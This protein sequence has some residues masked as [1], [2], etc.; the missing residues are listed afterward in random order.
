MSDT[1]LILSP[2]TSGW[3]EWLLVLLIM[4]SMVIYSHDRQD[5]FRLILLTLHRWISLSLT[6]FLFLRPNECSWTTWLRILAITVTA[7]V[8]QLISMGVVLDT[9]EIKIRD[10]DPYSLY[11]QIW[12][13]L[14]SLFIP[15]CILCLHFP[16]SP[17]ISTPCVALSAGVLLVFFITNMRRHLNKPVDIISIVLYLSTAEVLPMALL[18]FAVQYWI[19]LVMR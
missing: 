13:Y 18:I 12:F 6:L 4:M 16:S 17:W 5:W 10:W 15:F 3:P 7:D 11:N 2:L 19:L 14:S 8:I 1:P 9:F